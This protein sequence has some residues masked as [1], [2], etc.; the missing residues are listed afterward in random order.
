MRK[1]RMIFCLL[2]VVFLLTGCTPQPDLVGRWET[3]QGETLCVTLLWLNGDGSFYHQQ[4]GRVTEGTWALKDDRL[5]LTIPPVHE[6]D[7]GG[8]FAYTLDRE[9]GSLNTIDGL[10]LHRQPGPDAAGYWMNAADDAPKRVSLHLVESG[11][12]ILQIYDK[13]LPLNTLDGWEVYHTGKWSL[14]GLVLTLRSDDGHVLTYRLNADASIIETDSGIL[15][16]NY[17][18]P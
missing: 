13:D 3:S 8:M 11:L 9:T 5:I 18:Q 1:I 15:L 17:L 12:F 6:L 7:S 14:S 2:L 4:E 10:H 16:K